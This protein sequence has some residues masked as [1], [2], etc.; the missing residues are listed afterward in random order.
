MIV[1]KLGGSI[2]TEK[3]SYRKINEGLVEKLCD[4]LSH[5]KEKIV[6]IHGAGSFGHILALKN[7]L[8]K[9][10]SSRGKENSI[11][12]VMSDVLTLDSVIIDRLNRKHVRAVAVPPHAIYHG[13]RSDFRTIETLLSSGFVPVLYGDIIVHRGKYR[14]I[15]GDEIALDISRRFRPG[16]VVFVTDV[17]GLYDSDPKI[18]NSAKFIP[19]IRGKD[20]DI[21]DTKRDATGSMAGKM[22]RIKKI[23]TY[24]SKVAIING[25]KPERLR[26]FLRGRETKSTVIT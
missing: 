11:S 8:E 4:V 2:I 14:I 12:Q 15:S 9:P 24:T 22:E 7:G 6:L 21:V 10:G 23:V 20:I 5:N 25:N 18:N 13:R 3:D 17:D 1:L 19:N 16:T 26:N